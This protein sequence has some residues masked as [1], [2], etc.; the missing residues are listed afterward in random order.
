MLCCAFFFCPPRL[1]PRRPP[2]LFPAVLSRLP[3]IPMRLP[4]TCCVPRLRITPY[5][6]PTRMYRTKPFSHMK[7]AYP[8]PPRSSPPQNGTE[9]SAVAKV[10][11][12]SV[13]RPPANSMELWKDGRDNRP[14]SAAAGV[15]QTPVAATPSNLNESPPPAP[16]TPASAVVAAAAAAAAAA[17][18]AAAAAVV[19]PNPA[20]VAVAADSAGAA[21]PEPVLSA[22]AAAEP[23][24]AASTAAV[25]APSSPAAVGA[26][27]GSL[28]AP[29]SGKRSGGKQGAS[30]ARAPMSE[31]A[32]MKMIM[33]SARA[34]QIGGLIQ[35]V[36]LYLDTFR[37]C[38]LAPQ[39]LL[40]RGP[41]MRSFAD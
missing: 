4:C 14:S 5:P 16:S 32:Q 26:A 31:R 41:C 15:Q 6:L 27:P 10:P 23:K 18:S 25:A 3:A 36:L 39:Q 17:S 29:A 8:P 7:P 38:V 21:M 11:D 28:A 12:L 35:Q 34:V 13:A 33:V 30:A 24:V 2:V 19:A 20:P 40:V 9:S 1:P 22:P 37:V